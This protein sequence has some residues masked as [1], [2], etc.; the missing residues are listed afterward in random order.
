MVDHFL[1]NNIIGLAC[2]LVVAVIGYS[3]MPGR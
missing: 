1:L 3:T 2:V